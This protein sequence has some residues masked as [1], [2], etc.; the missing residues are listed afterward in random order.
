MTEHASDLEIEEFALG[1]LSGARLASFELHVTTCDDCARRLERAARFELALASVQASAP[2]PARR[3][4]RLK[5][6]RR[7]ALPA[8]AVALA[9]AIALLLLRGPAAPPDSPPRSS[10]PPTRWAG[11][12]PFASRDWPGGPSVAP[13]A[14]Q[15]ER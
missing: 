7:V 15:E 13:F 5:R 9:A 1:E 3:I 4:S 11:P 10:P 14:D 2:A 8:G 12:P 6:M